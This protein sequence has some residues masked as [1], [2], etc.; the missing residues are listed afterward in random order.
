MLNKEK[1][2]TAAFLLL[3]LLFLVMDHVYSKNNTTYTLN[4]NFKNDEDEVRY[5]AKFKFIL[6]SN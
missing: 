6:S 2:I 1:N 5:Q 4:V 3:F